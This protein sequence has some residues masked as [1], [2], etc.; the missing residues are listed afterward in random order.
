M[1][2]Y[3]TQDE[4]KSILD[5]KSTLE[6]VENG[7]REMGNENI[8]MP[9]RVYLH[10]DKGVLIAMPA[11]MPGLDAAGTKLVTV[12]PGNKQAYG[13]PAVNARIVLNSPEN[14][15]PLAIMDGTYVTAL[16]TGAAGATGIKYLSR[17]DSKEVGLCGLG[18]QGRSQLMGLMEV[19]PGVEK[20]KVYDI[21]PEAKKA[22][23]DEMNEK[24][25]GVNFVPV[26]SA[27]EAAEGSDIVITCTP[28]PEP[29]IDGAWLKKGCHVSAI[30]ADT[31][32][33][34]ELMTSVIERCD[35]LVV[36]FIPQAFV[37]G[38]FRIPKEEGV[39]TEEDIYAELGQIVA[40]KKEGRTSPDEVTLFKATGLAIQDVGTAHKVYQ[41][42]KEKGIGITLAG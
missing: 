36:D 41:L 38:D 35:K 7:F 19:R 24:Y 30:G 12:H 8:E 42:A 16:R 31:G 13:L 4:V 14:G 20:I 15:L 6:A 11:Y 2:L 18:V 1:T 17:E 37:T 22:F 23:V 27:K 29:F 26:D 28:S 32:A 9:A 25:S 5:M 39:I 40:G 3:L 21:I 33:K 10:F 34:R